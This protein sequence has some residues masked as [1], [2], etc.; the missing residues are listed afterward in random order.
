M[1]PI[2]EVWHATSTDL[3]RIIRDE[4]LPLFGYSRSNQRFYSSTLTDNAAYALSWASGRFPGNESLLRYLVPKDKLVC[5][6]SLPSPHTNL[7]YGT[8]HTISPEELSAQYLSQIHMTRAEA[9]LATI[10]KNRSSK[11][12]G[13]VTFYKVLYQYLTEVDLEPK[14]TWLNKGQ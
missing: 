5:F 7:V 10:G 1:H 14:I 11:F 13:V 3:A 8:T 2:I 6:G 12:W 4:K 9:Y